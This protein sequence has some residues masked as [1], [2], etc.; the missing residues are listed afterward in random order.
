M[1]GTV[2]RMNVKPVGAAA[3]AMLLM[4]TSAI[5]PAGLAFAEPART[6]A[7]DA[8]P[9][10]A[11]PA[12]AAP[13][14]APAITIEA[15][16]DWVTERT[17]PAA[18]AQRI[19]TAES[20]TAY[21]LVDEQFRSHATGHDD[22][23]RLATVVANRSGLESGGKLTVSYD[24]SFQTVGIHFVH[25]I[26]DGKVIDLTRDTAFRVVE[27]EDDLDDGI[28]SGSLKLIANL[29][30]VR[31]G[32]V[33]DYAMTFH[34]RSPLWPGQSFYHFTERYSD[35]VALHALRL[36]WPAGAA[37][38]YK[39]INSDLSFAVRKAASGDG[40][41]WEWIA[42]DPP[43][44][45]A[46]NDVPATA[47]FWGKVDVSTMKDWAEVSRW[48]LGLYQGDESLPDDFAARLDAIAK[49]SPA[50]ADR[51]TAA[52][53]YVQD[54]IRYVGEELGEGSYVPRRPKT[55]LERGYGDC[56]DKSLLLS[57][58]LRRL[59]IDAAPALVTTIAGARLPD[60]LPS[61]LQFNHV[62]VRAVVDGKVIWIDATGSHS[63]GLGTK[64]VP[65][66]LGYALPIREGQT[67]LE[68]IAGYAELAGRET[69]LER[70]TIDEKADVP[71]KLHVETHFTDARADGVRASWASNS[72]KS[73]AD[74][75][76]KFYRERF[77][78]LTASK[79]LE[80]AD[81]RDANALTMI[82]DYTLT[83]DA[84]A[85]G[86]LGSKLITRAFSLRGILPDR[87]GN[88]RV[89][90]LAISA[91]LV[92]EHA[93][94]M[95]V[96]DR[97][98]DGWDDL[99]EK[100]G[101]VSFTRRS[102]SLPD[103]LRIV[104]TINTGTRF[105]VPSS[106]AE[107]VYALSDK[108]KDVMGTEWYLDKTPKAAS[109]PKGVDPAVW[110]AI[111]PDMA[112]VGDLLKG[113]DQASQLEALSLLSALAE[114]VPHPSPAAGLVE[115]MRG[116]VLSDLRRPQAA[117]AALR[118]ATAQ[119]EGNA[120]IFRL[121]I[122]YE[123]DLGT[124]ETTAQAIVR[125]GKLHPDVVTGLDKRWIEAALQKAYALPPDQR[126][127]NRSNL[128]IALVDG[129]WR[130]SPLTGDGAGML[131]CALVAH[132]LRG[133]LAEARAGL[134]MSPPTS[135]LVQMS[136][137]RRHRML[138]PELDKASTDHFRK[139]LERD[140]ARAAE[141]AKAAPKD[142][143]AITYQMKTLRAL[144][145]FA[146]ALA[147]G[148]SLA[149][150]KVQLEVAGSD[151]FWLVN[152]YAL[153]LNA[154]GRNDEGLAAMDTILGFGVENYPELA[155]LAINRSEMVLASGHYQQ[156]LDALAEIEARHMTKLNLYGR[157][158]VWADKA[159]ALR[160]L[161]KP[162]QAAAM[163]AMVAIDPPANWNAYVSAA[164]C[165]KDTRAI[166]DAV[167]KRLRS[168]TDRLGALGLFLTFET[169]ENRTL[170]E[171]TK[172]QVMR[173]AIALPDVQAELAKWGR[174][175]RYAGTSQGWADY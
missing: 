124:P 141:V 171:R 149:T 97:A 114:K 138:W 57:I 60:R 34:S 135:T 82:E 72:A 24:P 121:W 36:I 109:A 46:E 30:D 99:D 31:V 168:E 107:A 14:S 54:N 52:V 169:P 28:I 81:D 40:T 51:F 159:C 43:A 175:L 6:E 116:A 38:R 49:A 173:E 69:V 145:R 123:I 7:A 95:H 110:A 86:K 41:E 170:Y 129:G 147:I 74:E 100:A 5:A 23:F 136:I 12:V 78:G 98:L 15:K 167:I 161:G 117:F 85:K 127:R 163:D 92:N 131:S 16:P 157:M 105:E 165:R 172:L 152:E 143:G 160:Q 9:S 164:A 4:A 48:A 90:P 63:G 68:K 118:S 55:V 137:D 132:S 10:A 80:L 112:K 47:F 11:K 2:R 153:N 111:K 53:R 103:G 37:P 122:A 21:L 42:A 96:A 154:L 130:Q 101:P 62:I 22:W 158:W 79:P 166:A 58:A 104:Y 148:K 19:A 134:A 84:F 20:G 17:L 64:I 70:F 94:E 44:S 146:D 8:A 106:D 32:D 26:R 56:K 93:I 75:N 144:G 91:Y 162:D 151:A 13:P 89:S 27:R 73:I 87:Q 18:S 88:P 3:L 76:L 77:P 142:Y 59:G 113:T 33:V 66:D 128:C 150:D 67:A 25:L 156:A 115:G 83:R 71:L 1:T 61:P 45:K 120:E 50:Q 65:S 102:T 125:T 35:P 133:E 139:S 39:A 126:E 119:Y 155:A 108:I 29:R 140:A 174:A